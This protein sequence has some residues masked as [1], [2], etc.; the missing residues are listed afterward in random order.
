M[1]RG[2]DYNRLLAEVEQHSFDLLREG[3]VDSI[4]DF[5]MDLPDRDTDHLTLAITEAEY[6]D[7]H[8]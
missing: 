3:K 8:Q 1:G 7:R 6:R 4:V 2:G 5:L